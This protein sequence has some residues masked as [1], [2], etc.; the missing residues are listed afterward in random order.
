CGGGG[1]TCGSFVPQT[2]QRT[3]LI[4]DGSCGTVQDD[5]DGDSVTDSID[6]CPGIANPAIIPGT[7]RQAD[8]DRDGR[9]DPC[10]PPQTVDDDNDGLPD[11]AV[12]F[13]TQIACRKLPVPSLVVVPSGVRDLNGDHDLFADAGEVARLTVFVKNN[14]TIDLTG[15]NLILGSSDPDISCVTKGTVVIPSLPAGATVDTSSA[16]INTPPGAGEFEF[17]VSQ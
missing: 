4:N 17:V 2:C 8:A 13:T 6:N 10:D 11:D 7:T 1:A 12:S 5:A 9:G 14:S 16:G 15:V 3:G